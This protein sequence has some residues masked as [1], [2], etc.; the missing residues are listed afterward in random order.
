MNLDSFGQQEYKLLKLFTMQFTFCQI[1]KHP[2]EVFIP[3]SV[4]NGFWYATLPWFDLLLN[5]G[6]IRRDLIDGIAD[7]I[8]SYYFL[9]A[10][11]LHVSCN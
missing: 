6:I 5:S 2:Y 3:W 9:N 11:G 4:D 8:C 7:V 10:S 1:C